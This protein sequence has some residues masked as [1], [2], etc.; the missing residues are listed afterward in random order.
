MNA[1]GNNECSKLVKM[2]AVGK[3]E[4]SK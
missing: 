3:N 2:N 1:V 4:C